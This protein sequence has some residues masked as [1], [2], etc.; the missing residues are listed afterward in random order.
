MQR[1]QKHTEKIRNASKR[2]LRSLDNNILPLR[3]TDRFLHHDSRHT[4]LISRRN[5]RSI[6]PS[7]RETLTEP[8]AKFRWIAV[9]EDTPGT[10]LHART[11]G[12]DAHASGEGCYV[13]GFTPRAKEGGERENIR[14]SIVNPLP[15]GFH[16]R[17][18]GAALRRHGSFLP[19]RRELRPLQ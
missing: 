7:A 3:V 10:N 9:D 5:E 18:R 4:F 15:S 14:S 8:I 1:I 13:R 17:W 6:P 16:P 19:R 2:R 12:Q 11:F